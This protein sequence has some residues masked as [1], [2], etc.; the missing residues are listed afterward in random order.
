MWPVIV[1]GIHS[2]PL[3]LSD[4]G[5]DDDSEHDIVFPIAAISR[6]G[7]AKVVFFGD[8]SILDSDMSSTSGRFSFFENL[9]SWATNFKPTKL[10]IGLI[11]K[12]QNVDFSHFDMTI[13]EEDFLPQP[14]K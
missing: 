10:K 7:S 14:S 12:I 1:T 9:F 8:P 4:F 6:A 2:Y 3:L 11:G 13:C 5:F